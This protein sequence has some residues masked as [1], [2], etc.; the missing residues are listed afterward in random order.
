MN[1]YKSLTM[2]HSNHQTLFVSLVSPVCSHGNHAGSTCGWHVTPFVVSRMQIRAQKEKR[3]MLKR[4]KRRS[5]RWIW[6]NQVP[7]VMSCS[8]STNKLP[9]YCKFPGN[10]LCPGLLLMLILLLLFVSL[11]LIPYLRRSCHVHR[12]ENTRMWSISSIGSETEVT[13][14]LIWFWTDGSYMEVLLEAL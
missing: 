11:I 5:K 7:K 12:R 13:G 6:L 1:H 14:S 3:E 10:H 9:L 4:V 8:T 2:I